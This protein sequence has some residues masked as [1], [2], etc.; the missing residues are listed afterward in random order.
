MLSDEWL[1]KKY[2]SG[3]KAKISNKIY[4]RVWTDTKGKQ[5]GISL[6]FE[7]ADDVHYDLSVENWAI[8]LQVIALEQN[9]TENDIIEGLR[10]YFESR[11]CFDFENDAKKAGAEYD[12]IAFY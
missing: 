12:K 1:S 7:Y 11:D 8:F 9:A 10:E 6:D 5:V 4:Y 3:N 2:T